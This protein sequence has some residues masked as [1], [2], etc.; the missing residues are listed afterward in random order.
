MARTN[1]QLPL[2]LESNAK[3]LTVTIGQVSSYS[4]FMPQPELPVFDDELRQRGFELEHL[5]NPAD[6]VLLAKA[7]ESAVVFVNLLVIPYMELGTIRNL[8]GHL[9][10][11]QWRSFFVDHPNVCF[12]S[13]GNPY[14]LHEMP[15]L[16]NLMLAYG[17]SAVSQKA[18][19]K[20]WLGEL[21][22]QGDCPVKLPK[23]RIKALT[24]D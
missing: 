18:A 1:K 15:H 8:V 16:P 23:L 2:K 20:V 13:F 12:T 3:V 9:G 19:V 21:E 17:N 24:Q 7:A 4:K 5:L 10:H 6:D 11:W 22:A 14:V